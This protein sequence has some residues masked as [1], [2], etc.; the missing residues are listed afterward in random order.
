MEISGR[1]IGCGIVLL[2]VAI[3]GVYLITS[4]GAGGKAGGY[5]HVDVGNVGVVL[6]Q[7][8]GTVETKLFPA[9]T[10]WQDQWERVIEVPTNQRTISLSENDKNANGDIVN[11]AAAVNTPTNILTVDVSCNYQIQTDKAKALYENYRDQIENIT[12]FENIQLEPAV[13]EALNYA[14]GD[15][16]TA[17]ALTT[18]GK[19]SAEQAALKMLNDEWGP[20]GIVFNNFMIRAI[21]PDDETK[22]LLAGTVTKQQ[23]MINA[24]LALQQ[25]KIDNMT[26]IQQAQAD[27]KINSLQNSSLTDL[28]V[29][30]QLLGQV[31]KI[32]LNSN[33]LMGMLKSK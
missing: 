26:I 5:T 9:G 15:E 13:K 14:L 8:H 29:Q 20:R 6:D 12:V 3:I 16:E 19:Q 32:V 11:T 10:H 4:L 1:T 28:Y 17:T 18:A 7:Y 23:D 21:K 33:D 25:Q 22:Q 24:R 31:H 30:D 27:A 2:V